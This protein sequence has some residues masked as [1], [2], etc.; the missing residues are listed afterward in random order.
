MDEKVVDDRLIMLIVK[1]KWI[2]CDYLWLLP[3]MKLT[4]R[5]LRIKD[6]LLYMQKQER[7]CNISCTQFRR[8][9]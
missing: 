6:I 4:R 5:V 3:K 8:M 2:N 9:F 1:I 7:Q